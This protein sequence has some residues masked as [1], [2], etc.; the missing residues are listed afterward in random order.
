MAQL[1][2][3]C[4]AFGG[5]LLSVDAALALIAERISVVVET[6][7]VPL[8]DAA[9]RVL[10]CDLVADM[11]VPPHPNSAVDGYAIVHADLLPDRATVLP[12]GGCAAAGHPLGRPIERGEAIRIFTGAPMPEGADTVMMQ[13][14][15]VLADGKVTLQPGIKCGGNRRHAGEDVE[16]G[17][18]ALPAGRRLRPADLGLAAALGRHRLA[19]Y[20]RLRVALL[21]TGDEVR[22]PGTPLPPGAIYDA[23]RIMLAS[24]LRGL[25]C[26]VDDLGIRPDR[27]A[28]L[29]ETLTAAAAEH[30]LIVTSGG[31]ST[32]EE[33]HVRAAIEK[34]G[35]LDFWR[36]AIKPGRPVALGKINGIPL[37]GLPGNPVAAALTFAVLG[38]PLIERLAGA[39]GEPST[40]F[41][42]RAGF[43]YKKRPGRREYV[44]ATLER[45][46]DCLVA[47]K[48]PKDGAGILSSIVRTEGFVIVPDERAGVHRGD[49]V[50]FM[51]YT[52]ILV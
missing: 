20:R 32:G 45:D 11:D 52:G 29:A 33:D 4:F 51:P 42:V 48:Y 13:E 39:S 26:R 43:S 31:V 23:N 40:L 35:R 8:A 19:V 46:G 14:D 38:R 44:R 5:A 21:S 41:P 50:D 1:S 47:Q 25:G 27:E 22:E 28:A 9:G 12:V 16:Q 49:A 30:D 7:T 24:L 17:S 3:D 18:V 2:D 6:E 10:A 37:I 36:L 15:C 34:L